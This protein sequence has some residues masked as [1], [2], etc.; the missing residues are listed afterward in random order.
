MK[1]PLV[2]LILSIASSQQKYVSQIEEQTITDGSSFNASFNTP[3]MAS[4]ATFRK[5][6]MVQ[7]FCELKIQSYTVGRKKGTSKLLV[8]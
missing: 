7:F 1:P 3:S 6:I 2:V 8:P 5:Q 4:S